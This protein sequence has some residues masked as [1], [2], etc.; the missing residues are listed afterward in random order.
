METQGKD[1][2]LTV[3]KEVARV[4]VVAVN[5]LALFLALID[6]LVRNKHRLRSM[7]SHEQEAE[8]LLRGKNHGLR[9]WLKLTHASAGKGSWSMEES[10]PGTTITLI[11]TH[12]TA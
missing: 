12:K 11:G 1:K 8:L 9:T 3:G 6:P 4:E 7:M 10:S 5:Q 2:C